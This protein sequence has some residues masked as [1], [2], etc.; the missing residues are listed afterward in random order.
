MKRAKKPKA[1]A[2]G[3]MQGSKCMPI[4]GPWSGEHV[5]MP[6]GG[7]MVFRVGPWH[8][9]YNSVGSWIDVGQS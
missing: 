9:H 2:R 7:T 5:F 8:G 4:T 3:K 1:L 6:A